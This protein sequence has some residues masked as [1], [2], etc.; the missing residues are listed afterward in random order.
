MI[1][2]EWRDFADR[3]QHAIRMF[4]KLDLPLEAGNKGEVALCLL[5][6]TISNFDSA[7]TLLKIDRIVEARILMRCCWENTFYIA[8][9][10]ARRRDVFWN[11]RRE[12]RTTPS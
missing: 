12:T 9:A 6:R 4:Q 1:P 5:A 8:K 3:V 7:M 10:R 11:T 2:T